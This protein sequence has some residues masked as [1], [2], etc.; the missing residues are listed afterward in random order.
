ML[1][2]VIL[3]IYEPSSKHVFTFL[4][5]HRTNEISVYM[6]AAIWAGRDA[7][8]ATAAA[9]AVCCSTIICIYI[10]IHIYYIIVNRNISLFQKNIYE[11]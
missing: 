11:H 5:T 7:T 9:A 3:C 8:A 4:R 6:C 2:G 10:Y 1:S